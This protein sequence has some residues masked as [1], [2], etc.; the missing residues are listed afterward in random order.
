M[1]KKNTIRLTESELKRVITE[2]VKRVLRESMYNANDG[3]ASSMTNNVGGNSTSQQTPKFKHVN[4]LD[5]ASRKEIVNRIKRVCTTKEGYFY[6]DED[7]LQKEFNM[8]NEEMDKN[9]IWDLVRDLI[10]IHLEDGT[11]Y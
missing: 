10:E 6:P 3:Y 5:R 8:S 9:G 7:R 2:S 1:S 11:L 4:T